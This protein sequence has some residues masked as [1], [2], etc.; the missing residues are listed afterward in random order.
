MVGCLCPTRFQ[1]WMGKVVAIV[2]AEVLYQEHDQAQPIS[3]FTAFFH[4]FFFVILLM[5]ALFRSD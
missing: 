5:D 1:Q 3:R 4:T 2:A